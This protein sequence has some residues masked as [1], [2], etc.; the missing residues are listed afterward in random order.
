MFLLS[1]MELEKE[2]EGDKT[3]I[4]QIPSQLPL[5]YYYYNLVSSV[6]KRIRGLTKTEEK[7]KEKKKGDGEMIGEFRGKREVKR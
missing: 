1:K 7:R 2:T 5:Y 4:P 6:S 3:V